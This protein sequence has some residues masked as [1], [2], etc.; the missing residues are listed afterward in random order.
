MSLNPE[1]ALQCLIIVKAQLDNAQ[2]SPQEAIALLGSCGMELLPEKVTQFSIRGVIV[3][4]P[5][6]VHAPNDIEWTMDDIEARLR[7]LCCF[8]T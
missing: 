8:E 1:R 2:I 7:Y 4:H 5:Y 6:I 3:E